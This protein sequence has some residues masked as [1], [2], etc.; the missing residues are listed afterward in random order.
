MNNLNTYFQN[1]Q[2]YN[3]TN[4]I[5]VTGTYIFKGEKKMIFQVWQQEEKHGITSTVQRYVHY[6]YIKRVI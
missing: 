3:Q 6:V 5:K 2:I 1:L 4:P